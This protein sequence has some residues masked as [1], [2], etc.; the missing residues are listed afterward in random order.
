MGLA[1]PSPRFTDNGDGTV[2]DNLTALVW[3]KNMNCFGQQTWADAL[4]SAAT[5][6]SGE[7]GLS[8][9]SVEGDWRLPSITELYSLIDTGRSSPALPIDHPFTGVQF[10][11][12]WSSTT[13]PE[14]TSYGWSLSLGA[15]SD[16]LDDKV[17]N[18]NYAVMVRSS[19]AFPAE[20]CRT[21]QTTSY[22][23]GDDGALQAG[24]A[25]PVP[26]FTD[27]GNGTV[28]DNLTGLI[29]LKNANCFGTQTWANAISGSNTLNSGECGLSDGSAEGDWRLRTRTN[30]DPLSI[31]EGTV[32]PCR[33]IISSREYRQA[34]TGRHPRIRAAAHRYGAAIFGTA[35]FPSELKRPAT[36]FCRCTPRPFSACMFQRQEQAAAR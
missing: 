27:N 16:K 35:A 6:N 32:P 7:C 21:G 24:H 4:A 15:G 25:W 8:D 2:T 26:R 20:V 12:Y 3:L 13:Y 29:W 17:Y 22:A 5:L 36:I 9:G 34:I 28:T 19:S 1:W 30:C 11:Y 18:P 31:M 23:S 14:M 33:Q 10:G